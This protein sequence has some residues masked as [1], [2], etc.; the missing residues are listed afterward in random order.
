MDVTLRL[1]HQS[2]GF[3]L[4]VARDGSIRL[5][6]LRCVPTLTTQLWKIFSVP[7]VSLYFL[8]A[9]CSVF[10]PR[11]RRHPYFNVLP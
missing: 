2:L 11:S 9:A 1:S 10:L 7:Y 8:R 4:V 5:T 3:L 6:S